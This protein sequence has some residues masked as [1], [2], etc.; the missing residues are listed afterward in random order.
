MLVVEVVVRVVRAVV[1]V[2]VV[3]VL[4]DDNFRYFVVY[5]CHCHQSNGPA[6]EYQ[7]VGNGIVVFRAADNFPSLVVVLIKDRPVDE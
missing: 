5:H 6:G 4:C 7:G 2:V 3:K 1:V